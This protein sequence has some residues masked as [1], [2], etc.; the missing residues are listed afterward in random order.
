MS[1]KIAEITQVKWFGTTGFIFLIGAV[2][3]IL[4]GIGFLIILIGIILE[5]VAFFS[6]PDK[7]PENKKD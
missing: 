4:F 3:I 1:E 2:T 7:L 6:L 5:I